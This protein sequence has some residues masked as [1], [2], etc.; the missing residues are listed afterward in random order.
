V[1]GTLDPFIEA[2]QN[3]MSDLGVGLAAAWD[4]MWTDLA[5]SE[6]GGY[7]LGAMD[8]V[9][10][11]VMAYW[12]NMIGYVQKA[13]ARFS[14]WWTGDVASMEKEI[15]RVNAANAGN[16]AQR[17]RDRP[18]FAGRT[19]LTDEQKAAMQQESKD[20]QAAMLAEGDKMRKDRG[21]RT[22]QN[23]V[24][25]A[26]AVAAANK[27]LQAQVDRFPVP[28]PIPMAGKLKTE[29]AGT[30]SAFGLG[31]LGT[32]SVEKQ[33]LDELKRIR[34]ELQRQARVGGIGP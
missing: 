22:R 23:V 9:L 33:Q 20:R 21:D 13:W 28:K 1:M 14:A 24:D 17:G 3:S 7:L 29:T 2:V 26:A 8:N 12:D 16:A 27:N 30:F 31:Q 15:E 11:G 19:G 4:Q 6:W 5:T 32:G 34:E 25:R 10:N 18:G